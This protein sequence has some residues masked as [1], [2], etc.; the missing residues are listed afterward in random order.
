LLL[1]INRGTAYS[2]NALTA[3]AVTSEVTRAVRITGFL[4]FN[5]PNDINHAFT[6]AVDVPN[7]GLT[8]C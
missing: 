8:S 5:L 6:I 4:M 3:I 2:D 7:Q 1:F